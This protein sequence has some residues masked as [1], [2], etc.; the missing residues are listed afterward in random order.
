LIRDEA[1]RIRLHVAAGGDEGSATADNEEDSTVKETR[2]ALS[3]T[4]SGQARTGLTEGGRRLEAAAPACAVGSEGE[5]W[6]PY[7]ASVA[8]SNR[9]TAA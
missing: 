2:G 4:G 9:P 6:L 8:S 1:T 5:G 3:K 7:G